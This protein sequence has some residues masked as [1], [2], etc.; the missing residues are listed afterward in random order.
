MQ[1][2]IGDVV[3]E[4]TIGICNVEGVRLIKVDGQ[5]LECYVFHAANHTTVLVP[6]TQI[7]KRGIRK[8]MSKDEAK[9]VLAS[10]KV[11][12]SPNRNDARMQY[13]AYREVINSGDPN[14]IS[15][16]L[17]DLYTLD[18]TNELKGKE[19]EMM[20]LARKFLVDEI[21]YIREDAKNKVTD[22]ITESL[23]QMYKKKVQKDREARKKN[24]ATPL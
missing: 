1:F 6:K 15:K 18:Q 13:S 23:K 12:T 11:P 17:R 20:E 21:T 5:M 3:V 8:P 9:K 22:D 16:L 10:L 19:R 2:K 24:A 4:P 14:K 7:Q